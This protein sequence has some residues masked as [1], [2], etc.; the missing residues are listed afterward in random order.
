MAK[1]R[2][3]VSRRCEGAQEGSTL[4]PMSRPDEVCHKTGT[5]EVTGIE[6]KQ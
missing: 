6:R 3:S 2:M 1:R 4:P 5:R